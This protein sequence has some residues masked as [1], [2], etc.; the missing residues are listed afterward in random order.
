MGIEFNLNSFDSIR[1]LKCKKLII[2][3]TIMYSKK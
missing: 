3:N 2:I 1:R